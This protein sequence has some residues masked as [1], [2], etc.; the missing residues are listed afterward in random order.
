MA[1]T[2]RVRSKNSMKLRINLKEIFG[3]DIPSDAEKF[4]VDFG[5]AATKVIR[6]RTLSSK[7]L[8]KGAKLTYSKSYRDSKKFKLLKGGKRLVD[9]K[10]QGKMLRGIQVLDT[11][12][13]TVTLTIKG[14]LN[15]K[16]GFNHDTGDTLPMRRFWD[17]KSTEL[18]KL[19]QLFSNRRVLSDGES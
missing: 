11:T 1:K 5:R 16:K 7:F 17:L 14:N 8:N 15:T 6:D 19:R 3:R 12:K 2:K 13:N 10:L 4:R 18:T 9:L